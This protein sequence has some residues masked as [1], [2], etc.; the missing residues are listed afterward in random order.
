MIF[1]LESTFSRAIF[2]VVAIAITI[3][4]SFLAFI[5]SSD[6]KQNAIVIYLIVMEVLVVATF[7]IYRNSTTPK[8]IAVKRLKN[9]RLQENSFALARLLLKEYDYIRET[10]A[11]IKSD[12]HATVNYFLIISGIFLFI[13]GSQFLARTDDL[14]LQLINAKTAASMLVIASIAINIIGWIYFM[15]LIRLRQA[16]CD[17]AAAMNQIK[18][19]YIGNGRVP[20]ELAKSA[21]LWDNKVTPKPGKK[22]NVSYYSAMLISFISAI[23]LLFASWLLSPDAKAGSIHLFSW[24]IALYHFVFQMTCYSLF[25]DYK[26]RH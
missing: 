21:F 14:A 5:H 22:S 26:A 7:F 13:I 3:I 1:S 9:P 16:W 15:H 20:D 12:R 10:A 6:L 8:I 11:Q 25:L 4:F 23:F 17:S 2:L 19:F 24:L 18:D